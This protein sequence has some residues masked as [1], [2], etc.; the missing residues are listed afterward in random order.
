MYLGALG[1]TPQRPVKRAYQQDPIAIQYWLEVTYPEFKARAKREK[2]LIFWGD[3]MGLRGDHVAG[4]SYSPRGR[5]PVVRATGKRL[6]LNVMSVIGN[7][8]EMYFMIYMTRMDSLL[9]ISFL[10]RLLRRLAGRKLIV[11]LDR[12]SSHRSAATRVFVERHKHLLELG[13][14]PSYSPELNPDEILNQDIKA[15]AG[16][17]RPHTQEELVRNTRSH[18]H[19]RQRQP[20]IVAAFFNKDEVRYAASGAD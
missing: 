9:L 15:H 12:H 1:H 2:A 3:E 16:K 10:K 13:Y 18:L 11:I 19:R 8:G 17:Q 5:T 14:V 4:R 7:L 20:A 6:R